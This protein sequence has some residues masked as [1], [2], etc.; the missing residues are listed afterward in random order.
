MEAGS[1]RHVITLQENVDTS[2]G[3]GGFTTSWYD[4][5]NH[6]DWA[7]STVYSVGDIVGPT[8]PNGY[9]YL[10]VNGGTSGST[11]PDWPAEG[12]SWDDDIEWDGGI[13]WGSSVYDPTDGS[14][15]A[16][17]VRSPKIRA[18]IW[19]LKA[20]EQLEAMKV[21]LSVTHRIRIRYLSGV[22]AKLRVKFGTRYFNIRSIINQ[23]E[24]NRQLEFLAEEII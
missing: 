2:D 6:D 20:T 16:W 8:T 12:I 13:E 3:M 19:P 7:A 15:V 21:Q 4:W 24:R 14:G 17:V 18:A 22:T 23:G 9:Y 11:E 5:H 1:L 10:C